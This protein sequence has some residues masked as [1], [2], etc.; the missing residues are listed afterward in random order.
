MQR[1]SGKN[2]ATNNAQAK[3]LYTLEVFIII[4]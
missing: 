4:G 2:K 3:H 1:T